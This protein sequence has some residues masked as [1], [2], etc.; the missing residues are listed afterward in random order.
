MTKKKKPYVIVR[1][2]TAGV[3]A[4]YLESRKGDTKSDK[5]YSLTSP[6]NILRILDA[7]ERQQTALER[8]ITEAQAI[9]KEGRDE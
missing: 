6:Q 9:L 2:H 3:H 8:G 5:F 1:A 7:L 4:G